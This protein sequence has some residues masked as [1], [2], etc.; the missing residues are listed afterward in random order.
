MVRVIVYIDGFNLYFGLKSK[1]WQRYYWLNLQQLAQKLLTENQRLVTTKYF[2]SRV[3]KPPEKSRKQS[4]YIEALE[5][6][7]DFQIFYGHYLINAF[8]CNKC[9]NIIPKPNE[10][11]TDV[12]IAVEILTDAFQDRFDKALII[13]ADSDLTGPI[14]KIRQLFPDKKA[15]VAFPPAR[16]S[17]ALEK[18]ANASFMIGRKKI[19]DSLFPNEVI[20]ADGYVLKRPENWK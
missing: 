8:E 15:V 20:K 13:S 6:L 10:K 2:T 14:K 1:G 4:T 16:Y 18:V 19:A 12:N 7:D 9:G 3:S 11:M 17:F 5:T